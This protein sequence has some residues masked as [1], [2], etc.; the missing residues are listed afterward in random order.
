MQANENDDVSK[1]ECANVLA[2]TAE[3]DRLTQLRSELI[4]LQVE[5][6]ESV[7]RVD[8]MCAILKTCL[9]QHRH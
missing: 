8:E 7:C 5:L 1:K 9:Q 6:N 2:I 3:I 4:A